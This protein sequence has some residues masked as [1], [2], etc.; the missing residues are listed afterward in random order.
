M[1]SVDVHA[2]YREVKVGKDEEKKHTNCQ[3][4]HSPAK[5]SRKACV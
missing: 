4:V 5:Y 1:A 2:L 3:E